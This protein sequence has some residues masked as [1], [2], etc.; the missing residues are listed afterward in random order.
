MKPNKILVPPIKIQG[1]K[2]KLVPWIIDN[3]HLSNVERW[4]EP[5]L[6]SGVVAFNVQ[7]K[8]A[9][10]CDSNPHIINFYQAIKDKKIDHHKVKSFLSKEGEIL[11]IKDAEHYYF[12][13]ERFNKYNEPLDFL[14]L[15]RSCFN[16]MIRFN[17]KFAFNVPYGHKSKRFS[18]SYITKI[19][20]QIKN[21]QLLIET[22]NWTFKCQP[23]TKTMAEAEKKD[24]IYC[25]PPYIGR[26]VDYYDSWNESDELLLN[27]L[28]KNTGAKFI[29]STWDNNQYRKNKYIDTIWKGNIKLNKEHFYHIGGK[30]TNR[31]SITEALIM[32]YKITETE[33]RTN[34]EIPLIQSNLFETFYSKVLP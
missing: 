13:R 6:G 17:Q 32:N 34:K 12:I 3:I 2:T 22:N 29:L 20:N 1:I 7:F 16:G 23:F 24:F 21:V 18:K 27:N 14:F 26:H 31:N 15:N 9:L 5:F 4:V 30:E 8:D 19:V 25:D 11:S 10:L 33:I 28:L